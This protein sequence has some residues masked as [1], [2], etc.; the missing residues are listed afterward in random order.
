MGL[1]VSLEK[2]V[3]GF[4]L[5]IKWDID[6]ELAVLFGS[7]GMG[8]SMTLQLIAGLM[9]PDNGRVSLDDKVYYDSSM[10]TDIPPQDRPF[11]YVF[12]TLALFPHMTVIG[13]ILYGAPLAPEHEKMERAMEMISAF[14]LAGLEGR[15]PDEISGGQKQR[16]AVARALIRWPSVLLLDE[17][18]SSL[19]RPLRIEMRRFLIEVKKE[20]NI[21]VIMVTHDFDEASAIANKVIIYE[22]GRI[23]QTGTPDGI[24]KAPVNSYVEQLV[25]EE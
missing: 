19:D 1:Q 22:H 13:N 2:K 16:V 8:K 21:P 17:P 18:F 9:K 15:Y 5:D 11:G 23:A 20:F 4:D 7:S 25:R 6:N 12:Q 24:R 10:R 3:N 14:K